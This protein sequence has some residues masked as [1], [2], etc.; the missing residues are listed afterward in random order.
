MKRDRKIQFSIPFNCFVS[1]R[2]DIVEYPK[3]AVHRINTQI[4]SAT[5]MHNIRE[6]YSPHI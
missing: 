4:I 1:V 6:K 2:V 3:R 5:K